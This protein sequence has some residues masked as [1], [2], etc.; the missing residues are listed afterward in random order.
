MLYLY[1]HLLKVTELKGVLPLLFDSPHK[2]ITFYKGAKHDEAEILFRASCLL[3][4]CLRALLR[5]KKRVEI[6]T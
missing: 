4:N 5:G 6:V 3:R 2:I 1:V